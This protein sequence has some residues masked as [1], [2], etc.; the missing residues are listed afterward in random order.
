MMI[1]SPSNKRDGVVE[2]PNQTCIQFN[3]NIYSNY[4]PDYVIEGP[5]FKKHARD[6]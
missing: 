2:N 6:I 5:S 3:N 1:T 4:T